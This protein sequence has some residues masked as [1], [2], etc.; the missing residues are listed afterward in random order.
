MSLGQY[1][2]CCGV[3]CLRPGFVWLVLLSREQIDPGLGD[4]SE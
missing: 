4:S 2:G 3:E 1:Q